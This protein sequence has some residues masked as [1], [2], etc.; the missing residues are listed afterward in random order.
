M[1]AFLR[2]SLCSKAV[3][4]SIM[5]L[6][7]LVDE[8]I[9]LCKLEE[10]KINENIIQCGE[11]LLSLRPQQED[12]KETVMKKDL[13]MDPDVLPE[14]RQEME[15]LNRMLEKA[16]RVRGGT[17]LQKDPPN[18]TGPMKEPAE[19]PQGKLRALP[20]VCT[21][22]TKASNKSTSKPIVMDKKESWKFSASHPSRC[23]RGRTGHPIG[24]AGTIRGSVKIRKQ[25][26]M[27]SEGLPL[28]F[29]G[30]VAKQTCPPGPVSHDEGPV[31]QAS[32]ELSHRSL[33][34]EDSG[35]ILAAFQPSHEGDPVSFV[36]HVEG[37][38]KA[39]VVSAPLNSMLSKWSSLRT[40]GSRLWDKVLAHQS[41]HVTERSHFMERVKATF[42]KE[43]P[44]RGSPAATSAQVD[45]IT[46]LCRDFTYRCRSERLLSRQTSRTTGP[47]PGTCMK[48]TYES[49]LML[50]GLEQIGTDLR[51]HAG[52][53]IKES[54]AWDHWRRPEG[55]GEFCTVRRRGGWG[56]PCGLT[57]LPPTLIYTSQAELQEVERLRLRVEL[58]QQEVQLQ[59]ALS[60]TM[61]TLS[62]PGPP[63]P[64][65]LRDIYSLLTEGGVQFPSLVLD[66]EPD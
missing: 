25:P 19:T 64:T 6:L 29:S 48:K 9:I 30:K 32:S 63:N 46:Q 34:G 14:E 24:R 17:A 49:F 33:F 22:G 5:S 62:S 52:Q 37:T 35:N 2:A 40:R 26:V 66:M 44:S 59:Q 43:W 51:K 8:S 28:E 50:E 53:L 20:P 36:S 1:L 15:L 54:E 65:A 56:D 21:K 4:A 18:S 57:L 45:R 47:E 11:I 61:V 12:Y 31:L 3:S 16:L 60:D 23:R 39:H 10:A 27:S 13:E 58:M 42:P 41:K 55:V 38:S 7:S